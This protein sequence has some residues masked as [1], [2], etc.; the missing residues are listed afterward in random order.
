MLHMQNLLELE[1]D[2]TYWIKRNE[3]SSA[4]QMVVHVSLGQIRSHKN[5]KQK[6]SNSVIESTVDKVFLDRIN[7]TNQKLWQCQWKWRDLYLMNRT[8]DLLTVFHS[9]FQIN[10]MKK[11]NSTKTTF[12]NFQNVWELEVYTIFP[13]NTWTTQSHKL[14]GFVG[15][16]GAY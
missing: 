9:P 8:T 5:N 6:K 11:T 4:W 2:R 16:V 3:E 7:H 15:F 12:T 1:N 14:L 10:K 13:K